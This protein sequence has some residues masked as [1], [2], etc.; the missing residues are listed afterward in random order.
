[1][2]AGSL[3]GVSIEI[4]TSI[5]RQDYVISIKLDHLSHPITTLYIIVSSLCF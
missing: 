3:F 5:D 4:Y 1:M 2:S